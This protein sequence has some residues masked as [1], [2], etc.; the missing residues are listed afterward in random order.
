MKAQAALAER[1]VEWRRVTLDRQEVDRRRAAVEGRV[2]TLAAELATATAL[3]MP[4]PSPAAGG[5]ADH[6]RGMALERRLDHRLLR[7]AEAAVKWRDAAHYRRL[8]IASHTQ[9]RFW[10]Q[11]PSGVRMLAP[12]AG[13]LQCPRQPMAGPP[14]PER[15]S[16]RRCRRSSAHRLRGAWYLL[17]RSVDSGGY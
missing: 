1:A 6:K 10:L 3:A 17:H 15:A 16:S 11:S 5:R 7:L 14:R 9:D 13:P 12:I 4:P 8:A 2:Q